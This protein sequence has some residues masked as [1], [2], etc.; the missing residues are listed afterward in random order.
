MYLKYWKS[1][2]LKINPSENPE[3]KYKLKGQSF[4][5]LYT[6]HYE[7]IQDGNLTLSS[8]RVKYKIVLFWSEISLIYIEISILLRQKS[9]GFGFLLNLKFSFWTLFNCI[10]ISF[11]QK[12]SSRLSFFSVVIRF[13]KMIRN[14]FDFSLKY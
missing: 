11:D 12:P 10:I 2:E 9:S 3:S 8:G 6:N 1:F 4:V 7:H 14:K 5:A 13:S